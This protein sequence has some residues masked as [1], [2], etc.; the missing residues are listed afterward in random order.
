MVTN[1]TRT[2]K[3]RFLLDL[4]KEG[5]NSAANL[6]R[7]EA[8]QIDSE[9]DRLLAAVG[10]QLN[11]RRCALFRL[12]P[13]EQR[14]VNEYEW[15]AEGATP[16]IGQQKGVAVDEYRWC[17]EPLARLET[18]HFANRKQLAQVVLNEKKRL[19]AEGAQ[20]LILLP[21]A[22]D[23]RLLGFYRLELA[24]KLRW[25][26][27]CLA[28]LQ[29]MA[30][31]LGAAIEWKEKKQWRQQQERLEAV[32]QL[33][34]GIAHQ[35]NNLFAS[36]LL[37]TQILQKNT[38]LS[39]LDQH[40][41]E[42]IVTNVFNGA[43]L[44]QQIADFSE[45]HVTFTMQVIDLAHFLAEIRPQITSRLPPWIHLEVVADEPAATGASYRVRA[46]SE[47]LRQ[48]VMNLVLNARDA[49]P[50]GGELKLRLSRLEVK[51][52][53]KPPLPALSSGRWLALTVS[54]N[55][56]GINEEILPYLFDPFFT[57]KA[58][59]Q[60]AGLGLSQVYGIVR[61]HNGH[62]T[63]RQRATGGTAVTIYL[64]QL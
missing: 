12:S 60:G 34:A 29:P 59:G 55:G 19:L 1:R 54:D 57:T 63:I 45:E 53:D 13:I 6:L 37:H 42:T 20:S 27:E 38:Q 35:F 14:L 48:A 39:L 25:P 5:L 47:R 58:P 36:I 50:D 43:Q 8:E 24:Q 32:K 40:R 16:L 28:L 11:A 46:N 51:A 4:Q 17:L 31:I 10:R 52:A 41:L 7:L 23:G 44:V 62:L 22:S 33:A 61:R 49:L 15:C 56:Q 18:L 9:I 64:E 30:A 2:E 26:A 3:S 21:L